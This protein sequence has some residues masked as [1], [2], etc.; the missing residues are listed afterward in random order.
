[1]KTILYILIGLLL[2][3]GIFINVPNK[4]KQED[5][6]IY[7]TSATGSLSQDQ[8]EESVSILTNRLRYY[9]IE[10]F[11]VAAGEDGLTIAFRFHSVSDRKKAEDLLKAKGSVEFYETLDRGIILRN[12]DRTDP[13]YSMMDIPPY[14]DEKESDPSEIILGYAKAKPGNGS[15]AD[16]TSILDDLRARFAI[17]LMWS[18]NSGKD[19]RK[20]L[21]VLEGKP[22]MDG[23]YISGADCDTTSGS[24][25]MEFDH[26]GGQIWEDYT[27]KNLDRVIAFVLDGKVY[28]APVVRNEIKSGK[29]MITGDFST[30]EMRAIAAVLRFGKLPVDLTIVK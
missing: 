28:F 6:V 26:P 4:S 20:A 11:R 24:V 13:I 22:F 14:E 25:L 2:A 27:H 17:N 30:G 15:S 29:C 12:I 9:G 5:N 18:Y 16:L 23:S 7:L 8:L 10:D 21:Y 3:S 1:M 19:S